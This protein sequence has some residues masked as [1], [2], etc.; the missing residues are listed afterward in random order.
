MVIWYGNI[1]EET[2]YVIERVMA[3]PWKGLAWVVF[4]VCFIVPFL[5]L[6][7]KKVKTLPRFMMVFCAVIIAGMWL[8]HLLLLGPALNHE[9]TSIPLGITDL[10]ITIGFFG[11]MAFAV[12]GYL[13]QFPELVRLDAKEVH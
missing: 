13:K 2:A 12:S 7:N 3:A 11:L 1:S 9:A 10:L 5:V 4:A 6:I 8:E